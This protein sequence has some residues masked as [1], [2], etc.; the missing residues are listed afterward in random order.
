MEPLPEGLYEVST[1]PNGA[2][3]RGKTPAYDWSAIV[4]WA[5]ANPNRTA[6]ARGVKADDHKEV[7]A[8][9]PDVQFLGLSHRMR[10]SPNGKETQ[11]VDVWV[12][13]PK[14]TEDEG[15]PSS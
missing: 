7:K 1:P 15:T 10:K 14:E 6:C 3:K 11:V 2:G 8:L 13:F 12:R 9:Y 4:G 5:R